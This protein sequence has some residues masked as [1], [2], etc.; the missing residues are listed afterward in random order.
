MKASVMLDL[1]AKRENWPIP[2][3]RAPSQVNDLY[4]VHTWA[5]E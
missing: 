3:T 2:A 5:P 4:L 1:L